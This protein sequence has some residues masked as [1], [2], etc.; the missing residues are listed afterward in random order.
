MSTDHRSLL[1]R[2]RTIAVVGLSASPDKTAH[3]V[4]AYLQSV[5]Y[6]VIPVNP[7]A[8]GDVLGERVHRSLADVTEPVDIVD[9]F[10][11]SPEAAGI[12]EQAVAIGAGALWLQ[13]GITSPEARRTAEA[14]G[15]EYV[16]DTCLGVAV[17]RADIRIARTPR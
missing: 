15:M 3:A 6:R 7:N 12:A 5:G 9:V 4:P 11:P 1:D 13:H 10:R 16:E 14:A 17:A 8:T 2:S